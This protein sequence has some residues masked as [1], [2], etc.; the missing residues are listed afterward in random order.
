MARNKLEGIETRTD[1]H[2]RT[3]YR[4]YVSGGTRGERVRGSWT[5]SMSEARAWRARMLAKIAEGTP[6][7]R[8]ESKLPTVRQ[9]AEAFL[10]GAE[11][12][13]ILSRKKTLYAARTLRDYR[14]AFEE[15]VFPVLG[16]IRVDQL[17]RSQV[18]VL[19]DQISE[20]RAG[21]TTRNAIHAL[22]ALYTYLLPRY[23]DI[24]HDPTAGLELPRPS[25]PRERYAGPEE[26]DALLK[27]L[28]HELAVPYAL[29]FMAGLRRG[30]IQSLP[31]DCVDLDAGWLDVRYSLDPKEG[32]KGPKSGAG[33]RSVPIVA[34]LR[35]YLERQLSIVAQ[36][37][38]EITPSTDERPGTLLLPSSR[39]SRF[40]CLQLGSPYVRR[41]QRAW[42]A[43]GLEPI[44][45]H[46][47][48]HSFATALIRAGYDVKQVSEWVGHS[49]AS[50]TLNIYAKKRGRQGDVA[51]L[52]E[53]MDRHLLPAP[54]TA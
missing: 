7:M 14:A 11:S 22:G 45:L 10:T 29:A 19:A 43:H 33:E 28:P 13:T 50:T 2:G 52:T 9:A 32:F 47:G 5:G 49:Q 15:W 51:K 25:A 53:R 46:E 31:V 23:D 26:M 3:R 12:G 35:P 6:V 37:V 4:P 1:T 16:R 41:C 27:A 40:G 20:L 24:A 48:R 21:A 36:S 18:Q 17:R 39:E 30:E 8:P 38:G 42:E 44:G 54:V 34:G